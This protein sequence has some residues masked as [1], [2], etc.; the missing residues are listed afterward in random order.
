MRTGLIGSATA[1]VIVLA[2][3][4]GHAGESRPIATPPP[5]SPLLSDALGRI[6]DV[7]IGPN[8]NIY[9]SGYPLGAT[10][11]RVLE[12]SPGGKHLQ[13]FLDDFSPDWDTGPSAVAVDAAGDVYTALGGPGEVVKFSPNGSVVKTLSVN[14]PQGIAIDK[15]GSVFV[16][17]FDG[18]QILQFSPSGKLVETL[19]PS[20]H[21]KYFNTVTG[22]AI[23]P[24]GNLYVSN[25]RDSKI[26]KMSPDGRWLVEWG[27][28]FSGLNPDLSRPESIAVDS[29]GN[30]Y[31]SDVDN[32]RVV[33][34]SSAGR[35]IRE[36][37]LYADNSEAAAIDGHG[38]VYV[39]EQGVTKFSP[40]GKQLANWP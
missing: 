29:R 17:S 32:G 19:G 31:A 6:N 4:G 26:V 21:G 16:T 39:A 18:G 37:P 7:V 28:H 1:L 36:L 27:P 15:K 8:G 30:I 25:H 38:T 20:F 3:C 11:G 35:L 34:I 10:Y 9:A 24:D 2:A 12:L 23:G 33:E 14:D 13:Q 5:G 22:I 40:T